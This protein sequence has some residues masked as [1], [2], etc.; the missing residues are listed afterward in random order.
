M[1]CSVKKGVPRNFAKIHKKTP[2][3]ES[4]FRINFIKNEILAQV[5]SCEFCEISKNTFFTEHLRT[6]LLYLHV[7]GV[8]LRIT[9]PTTN[10]SNCM[11]AYRHCI[12]LYSLLFWFLFV[13]FPVTDHVNCGNFK[14][15]ENISLIFL[16]SSKRWKHIDSI[17]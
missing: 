1:Q 7:F 4:L 5:F 13:Q 10:F 16:I 15:S 9:D 6:I 8:L 2:V 14:N 3:S 11:L 17:S 12:V